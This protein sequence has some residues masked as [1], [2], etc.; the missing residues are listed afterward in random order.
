MASKE[1][2]FS[3][4]LHSNAKKEK[5]YAAVRPNA[6]R[7]DAKLGEAKLYVFCNIGNTNLVLHA[8]EPSVKKETK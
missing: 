8:C 2:V 4:K 5:S 3:T 1:I 6:T 7:R